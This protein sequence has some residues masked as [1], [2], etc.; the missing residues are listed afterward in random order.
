M[1]KFYIYAP[2]L[3]LISI[4]LIGVEKTN[5]AEIST[6]AGA[7][8]LLLLPNH[9]DSS[10]KITIDMTKLHYSDYGSLGIKCTK[11]NGNSDFPLQ[12]ISPTCG[13]TIKNL[14]D[15][16]YTTVVSN[17]NP[18]STYEFCLIGIR[19]NGQSTGYF[20]CATITTTPRKA[21]VALI[22]LNYDVSAETKVLVKRYE[23]TIKHVNTDLN[24]VEFA[25]TQKITS[26]ELLAKLKEVY[27]SKNLKYVTLVG[28]DLPIPQTLDRQFFADPYRHLSVD[29]SI[30]ER[31]F[32]YTLNSEVTIAAIHAENEQD[33]QNYF[34]RLYQ[35]YTGKIS[36]DKRL[37]IADGMI[38]S[39]ATI[40]LTDTPS[41]YT[42]DS[43]DYV[44]GITDYYD[45]VT[46]IIPT[47]QSSFRTFLSRSH[48]ITLVNAHG[49]P[50]FHFP[51]NLNL[52]NNDEACISSPIIRQTNPNSLFIIGISCNIGNFMTLD[53]P[54]VAYILSGNSL[55]GL[56]S[57]TLLWD[58][59]GQIAKQALK[60]LSSGMLIGDIARMN[61]LVVIGD[62][63]LRLG[64]PQDYQPPLSISPQKITVDSGKSVKFTFSVP[65]N[66]PKTSMYVTCPSGLVAQKTDGTNLCN[67]MITF[68]SPAIS[69]T[70]IQMINNSR[71]SLKSILV[72]YAYFP[73]KPV[74]GQGVSSEI[75]VNPQALTPPI[76]PTSTPP[77]FYYFRSTQPLTDTIRS[78]T[79]TWVVDNASYC[80][81]NGP[82]FANVRKTPSEAI[83]TGNIS[84]NSTY[85]L[86]CHND[87][88]QPASRSVTVTMP[89]SQPVYSPV[90]DPTPT[91]TPSPFPYS[92]APL[93][94]IS[95]FRISQPVTALMRSTTLVWNTSNVARCV[96][97]GPNFSNLSVGATGAV[98][99]GTLNTNGT[100]TLTCMNDAGQSTSK[101]LPIV[102]PPLTTSSS[103]YSG[104]IMMFPDPGYWVA[105]VIGGIEKIFNNF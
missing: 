58:N 39:E 8:Q 26:D 16:I 29:S 1:K 33:L 61:G 88:G 2:L 21:P 41:R 11:E 12:N 6:P 89:G 80:I 86:T 53:S 28:F 20:E 5:A 79:L 103:D 97:S 91:P 101:N 4:F 76:S 42:S 99:T 82:G 43:V 64:M 87:S 90:S 57:E 55:A 50:T 56:G 69:S 70:T 27:A 13:N 62:P 96:I 66:T 104:R 31:D 44:T 47:W 14:Q 51:C 94:I 72:F 9:E 59:N 85:S 93:P 34:N 40:G 77:S 78:T 15:R 10:V 73:D 45:R 46:Q 84:S 60:N 75:T 67:K 23:D 24:I 37:F 105:N 95:E 92:T 98:S 18:N 17:L 36:Y 19:I 3:I 74:Y 52:N 25:P 81:L 71:E 63:F 83:S 30:M 49:S 38:P 22:F 100:Y 102:V 65:N 32:Y 48:E 35:F 7:V 54:M 68:D